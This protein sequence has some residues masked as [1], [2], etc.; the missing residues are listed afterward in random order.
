M[1]PKEILALVLD[2]ARGM[3][4]FRWIAVAVAWM[5]A[6]AGMLFVFQMPNTYSA[7][8]RVYVDTQNVLRP[9][10]KGMYVEPDLMSDVSVM[11][12]VMMSRPHLEEV[13]RETD[14]DLEAENDREF[15]MLVN[16]LEERIDIGS[17]R[18]NV[19][20]IEFTDDERT[21]ALDV[22]QSL[23]DTFV[24]NTLGSNVAS[25]EA[26][27]DTLEEQIER[28]E[29][30]L[31]EAEE[32][33]KRFKQEN[34]GRMPG[35]EGDYYARLQAKMTALD[36]AK[37]RLS[38]AQDKKQALENKLE[39]V[40][41]VYSS[42]GDISSFDEQISNLE[43]RKNDLLLEYTER[44]PEV[45]RTQNL[46]DELYRKRAE[47]LESGSQYI[48]ASSD[49]DR[50]SNPV[51]QDIQ[52]QMSQVD[53]EIASVR[54]EIRNTE[55]D[56]QRL[57]EQVNVIPEVE[58]ELARLNRDYNVVQQRYQEMLSRWE[59][60]QTGK[61]VSSGRDSVT[62]KVIEP[63]F[64]PSA[65]TGPDRTLFLGM[66]FVVAVGAGVGLALLLN[67]IWPVFT[68]PGSL[69]PTGLPVIG[70]INYVD[71]AGGARAQ[72]LDAMAVVGGAVILACLFLVA[73]AFS[74]R[75]SALM[76]SALG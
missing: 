62:F 35:A 64:A 13:I 43:E 28:Y 71:E 67:L 60:L 29:Q 41:P 75:L 69:K 8:T 27:E 7:S 65:P 52:I 26:A 24:N 37:R 6:L 5:I 21:Q 31:V 19:Y 49:A 3:W 47:E 34:V 1:D 25:S 20:T 33:L 14:M 53:V 56:I 9:L 70:T 76:L 36:D 54:A 32:R 55:A 48:D 61:L 45:V 44:H 68:S 22:V 58:A 23:L 74:H 10:L 12:R 63:P 57:R 30:R 73:S 18:E 40:D 39:G 42:E 4:R 38:V 51:F 11:T 15:E 50:V 59:D 2:H 17:G 66:V 72:R 16:S 46:L